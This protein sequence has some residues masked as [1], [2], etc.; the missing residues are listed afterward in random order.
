[1]Y[2]FST[3]CM[4]SIPKINHSARI[5]AM[6]HGVC[7]SI[8]NEHQGDRGRSPL[9]PYGF[10]RI[11]GLNPGTRGITASRGEVCHICAGSVLLFA[12]PFAA[13]I[14]RLTPLLDVLVH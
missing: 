5:P 1:M 13:A 4:V 10:E 6:L 14:E 12:I 9:P 2:L 8:L 11:L 3:L 7:R